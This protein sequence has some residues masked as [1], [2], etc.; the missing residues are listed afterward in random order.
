MSDRLVR[1]L[2]RLYP[3]DF[4][5]AH[6]ENL[7]RTYREMTEDHGRT[8]STARLR[9][10]LNLIMGAI[11]AHSDRLRRAIAE[12]TESGGGRGRHA[13]GHPGGNRNGG[14]GIMGGIWKDLRIATRS[15]ARRPGFS[16]GVALT[17]GLGIGATTTIFGVVQGVILRPLPYDD[18]SRLVALGALVPGAEWIDREAGLQALEPISIANYLDLRERSRSFENSAF[19]EP[20]NVILPD[21]GDGPEIVPGVVVSSDLFEIL[22]V[23][24]F[25]GRTFAPEEYTGGSGGIF[26]LDIQHGFQRPTRSVG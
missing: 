20:A 6:A 19:F 7:Q 13:G 21:R 26:T 15:L 12:R 10:G 22:G 9:D 2:I 18:P 4:R 1:W 14:A 23:S 8:S 3:K 5:K 25:L 11:G 17:L 16:L 24:P